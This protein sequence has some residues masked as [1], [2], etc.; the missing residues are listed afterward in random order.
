MQGAK[1]NNQELRT[2]ANSRSR[3]GM[4]VCLEQAHVKIGLIP[5][6]DWDNLI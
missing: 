4:R 2:R 3:Q 5:Q 1:A 6:C